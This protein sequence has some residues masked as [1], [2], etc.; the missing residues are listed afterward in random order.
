MR[1]RHIDEVHFGPLKE[2]GGND[3]RK[4]EKDKDR[5]EVRAGLEWVV[6]GRGKT[7]RGFIEEEE[8]TRGVAG[9]DGDDEEEEDNSSPEGGEAGGGGECG[10]EIEEEEEDDEEEEEE[11]EDQ[12]MVSDHEDD[13]GGEILDSRVLERPTFHGGGL[14][15]SSSV[16]ME[17]RYPTVATGHVVAAVGGARAGKE[18][19]K[20]KEK[21]KEKEK[22]KKRERERERE[23][24]QYWRCDCGMH[25]VMR[26]GDCIDCHRMR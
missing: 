14:Q 1:Y 16:L 7:K 4:G 10:D 26:D 18:K 24:E 25:N 3:T 15:Q 21:E 13:D 17:S 20:D 9:M 22:E 5:K 11:D 23:W 6:L 2:G 8:E 19:K 12:I